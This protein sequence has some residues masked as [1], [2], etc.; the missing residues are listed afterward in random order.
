M[1]HSIKRTEARTTLK[2]FSRMQQAFNGTKK[3]VKG[4]IDE[5]SAWLPSQERN[6]GHKG[7][8]DFISLMNKGLKLG[9]K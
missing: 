1:Y 3:S 5:V 4:F 9:K 6:G 2:S 8:D 7:V